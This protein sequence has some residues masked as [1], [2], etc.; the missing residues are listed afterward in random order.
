MP[1]A[2]QANGPDPSG[3][4]SS[5]PSLS[6]SNSH[7]AIASHHHHPRKPSAHPEYNPLQPP[8]GRF[9]SEV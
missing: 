4:I 5:P 3:A 1:A 7:W 6:L 9:T 2:D 8:L